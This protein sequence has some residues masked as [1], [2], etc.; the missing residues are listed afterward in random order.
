MTTEPFHESVAKP[1]NNSTHKYNHISSATYQANGNNSNNSTNGNDDNYPNE[2]TN[3]T[4]SN[5]PNSNT[6]TNT[7]TSTNYTTAGI[8]NIQYE[9]LDP[10]DYFNMD[11]VNHTDISTIVII[12]IGRLKKSNDTVEA[13]LGSAAA[14]T[15]S[16]H[17]EDLNLN[18]NNLKDPA[19][20]K[21]AQRH[22]LKKKQKKVKGGAMLLLQSALN[23]DAIPH[24]IEAIGF[25]IHIMRVNNG[26]NELRTRMW[27]NDDVDI[28]I[29]SRTATTNHNHIHT[30][31]TNNP[32]TNNNN[33]NSYGNYSNNSDTNSISSQEQTNIAGNGVSVMSYLSNMC[34]FWLPGTGDTT[35]NNTSNNTSNNNNYN[36]NYHSDTHSQISEL[37]IG[38]VNSNNNTPNSNNNNNINNIN[39]S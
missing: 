36:S 9:Y 8:H 31:N 18:L 26:R 32:N 37:D 1:I 13:S 28:P 25:I 12:R 2:N 35:T 16:V 23:T 7:N 11:E 5:I 4:H 14:T 17:T 33:N 38:S 22:E 15:A 34:S 21:I 39:N 6:N 10:S 24:I 29:V 3:N 27:F 20:K 30:N 19:K